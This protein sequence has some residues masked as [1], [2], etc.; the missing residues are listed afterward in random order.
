[1]QKPGQR[2]SREL[3][4]KSALVTGASQHIG[5]AIAVRFAQA[6]ADVVVHFR[7]KPDEAASVVDAI[8]EGGSNA[9]ALHA[10]L[11]DAAEVAGLI[12]EAVAA[13]GKLDILVNNAGS[14]PTGAFLE[15]SH[16]DWQAMHQSN[17][18]SAFLCSQAAA[19]HMKGR[20]RGAIVNVASISALSPG[21][22]HSHYNSAKASLVMLT[23]SAAQELGEF[24]IRVNAVSPGVINRAGIRRDWPDGVRRWEAR[25]PLKRMGEPEDVADACL[26]LASDAARWI[27]GQ[28]LVV[29][30]GMLATS[31]F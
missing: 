6:G 16:A 29:D 4:G 18:D 30:G 3:S 7:G 21:R 20:G 12:D 15:L 1:M 24:G 28:N 11:T 10:E 22:E 14:F 8:R 13:F 9:L 23:R 25:V 19:R 31:I 26:F 17:V 2:N 27:S 5:A